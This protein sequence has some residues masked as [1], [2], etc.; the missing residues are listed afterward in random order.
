MR[1]GENPMKAKGKLVK[2]PAE[3]TV[4]VLNYIPDN[5][6]YFQGQFDS[7]QL[8]LASIRHH[9]NQPFEL[10]VVDNGSCDEV[11]L[12]L[13]SELSSGRIDYLILNSRNVGKRNGLL[14][15]LQSAPGSMVFYTDGDIYFK[16]GWMDAHLEILRAFPKAGLIGGIPLRSLAEYCTPGTLR[17]VEEN[18]DWLS[19]EKGELIPEEWTREFIKSIG[20]VRQSEKL[21]SEWQ[22]LEDCRITSNGV[23]CYVGASH[24]QFLTTR[25]AIA[26]LPQPR[27][28]EAMGKI[29][30]TLDQIIEREGLLRLSAERPY[31]YHIGNTISEGWVREEFERLMEDSPAQLNRPTP[32]RRRHWFWGRSK[33]RSLFQWVYEWAFDM[34]YQNA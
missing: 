1:F 12:F 4:G 11:R 6:G 21:V 34:Y 24:M 31:V 14:Q 7:L 27:F 9:A 33:V 5:I 30:E 20:L 28:E 22:F 19:V 17:W 10:M 16:P 8:C 32:A 13:Q 25:E 18:K 15:V 29:T 26:K 2:P 23:I 3:I